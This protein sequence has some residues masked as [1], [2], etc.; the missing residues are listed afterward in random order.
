MRK[1]FALL[2]CLTL[3]PLN[4]PLVHSD[5]SDIFGANIEPNIMIFIDS[6]GSMDDYI[7]QAAT[8]PY[9]A[10]TTYPGTPSPLPNKATAK[11]YRCQSGYTIAQCEDDPESICRL[12]EHHFRRHELRRAHRSDHGRDLEWKDQRHESPA[13]HRELPQLPLRSDGRTRAEDRRRP[14][15]GDEPDQQHGRRPLRPVEVHG[16]SDDN[17]VRAAR[18]SS[19]TSVRARRR[20]PPPSPASPPAG[21]PR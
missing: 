15:R 4:V 11:V 21:G 14:T 7:D 13:P 5:D 18:R 17:W 20:S 12:R 8:A 3:L 16:N 19:P 10:A 1:L 2:L 9:V 6:S